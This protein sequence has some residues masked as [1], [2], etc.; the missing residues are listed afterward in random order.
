[1]GEGSKEFANGKKN[2]SSAAELLRTESQFFVCL[3]KKQISKKM[4]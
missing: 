4:V 3:F 1:M 2:D